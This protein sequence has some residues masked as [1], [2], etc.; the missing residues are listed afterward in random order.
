LRHD[1]NCEKLGEELNRSFLIMSSLAEIQEAIEKLGPEERAE[2]WTWFQ[3]AEETDELVVAVDEG[4]QAAEEGRVFTLE[5]IKTQ[6]QSW[7]TK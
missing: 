3:D 1:D 4:I 2:L 7:I 5:E 6:M